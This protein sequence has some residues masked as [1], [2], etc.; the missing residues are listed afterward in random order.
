MP[1]VNIRIVK[2]VIA[3][4]PAGKKAAISKQVTAAIVAATGLTN[5][6]V[7]IVFEEV[8]ARDWY[9]GEIDVETRRYKK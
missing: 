2:E 1:F 7:W 8:D 9:L 5:E 3:E 6:D 4:D